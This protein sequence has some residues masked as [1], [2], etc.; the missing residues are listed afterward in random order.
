MT[1]ARRTCVPAIVSILIVGAATDRGPTRAQSS[2]W[3]VR[4]GT[5]RVVCSLTVGGSFEAKST[6]IAGSF[7]PISSTKVWSG[8]FVV[9]LNTLDTGIGLRNEHL[10]G[11]YLETGR[12]EG[13]AR[14]LLTEVTLSG[15][16]PDTL[17]GRGSFTGSLRLHGR[18]RPVGGQVE[19]RQT[20]PSLRVRAAFP[21]ALS[22]FDIATPRYLGVGV[23]DEVVVHVTIDAKTR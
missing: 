20:G 8:E 1:P 7:N 23:R 6:A 16:D 2:E 15:I 11:R 21:V 13:Y 22:Q 17:T 3:T 18:T 4:S 5:V 10:R 14:A 19:V 12:G 9:D